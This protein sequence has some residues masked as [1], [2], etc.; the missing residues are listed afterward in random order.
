MRGVGVTSE[1]K[2]GASHEP[3]FTHLVFSWSVDDIRN[4]D[5]YRNQVEK[6]PES[7]QSVGVYLGSFVY[8]LLEETR[9][10]LAS[11]MDIIYGAPFAEVNSLVER[12]LN[13]TDA[14]LRYDVVVDYWRNKFSDR[15]KEPYRTLPG[16]V[17][18][19]SNAKLETVSDL[20]RDGRTWT[21][22]LVT[23]I[24]EDGIEDDSSSSTIFTVKASK[25]IEIK[26]GMRES[27]F[28]TFLMNITTYQRIWNSLRMPKNL[29]IIKEVLC[30]DS[31][32]Q[33]DCELCCVSQFPKSF[34]TSLLSKLN[35]FQIQ[36][37]VASLHRIKCDHKP[38][39]ELIWGPPGTG[40][41]KTVSV[42]LFALL[43][44]NYR[45]LA[46]A[47]TNV[48]IREV[49]SRVLML[50]RES[51][52][53]EEKGALFCCWGDILLFGNKDRLKL[54]SDI[55]E[56]YLDY[57]VKR[58]AECLGP[59]TGWRHCLTS[60]R[61]F[62]EGCVSE[63]DV[64]VENEMI[65]QK[66]M[67]EQKEC[68]N[69]DESGKV[70]IKSFV[71]FVRGRFKSTALSLRRC[72]FV[73]CTHFPRRFILEQNFTSMRSL[74]GLLYD[75]EMSL[76]RD[77]ITTEEL[78][79]VFSR[80]DG[81]EEF[82]ESIVG[83]PSL[84][85]TRSK[86]LCVVKTL[87]HSLEEL[88]LPS[89][90]NKDSMMEFCFQRA[91]LIF[92]TAST[93]YKLRSV[94]ME[95]LDLL[96]IDEAAQLK[97]CESTIP[98]Q[99]PGLNHA[100]LAGDQCQLPAMVHSKVC[101][102]A[103]FG[104]SLF[105]RLS[106]SGHSKHLLN[107]QYRMHPSISLFPNAKFYLNQIMDAPH[108]QSKSYEKQYLPGPMFGP[109]SFINVIGGREEVDDDGR[110]RRNMVEV[111]IVVKIVQHL[112]TAW[113][114]SGNTLSIGV[115]S[116]YA[117]QVVA[118]QDKLG[119]KY[120][121][122]DGFTVKVKTIDGFQ[123]GEE[124]VVV[125]S[126]VRSNNTGSVGFLSSPQR[127]NVALTRARHCLWIL[128]NDRTLSN[129]DSIWEALVHD[130]KSR[131]CFFYAD[132]D[133]DIAKT[134]LD[135]KKEL[136]QLDDLLNENSVLF[137][138]ARWK[139]LFSDNFK[140]SFKKLS[141]LRI[142]KSII[143]LLLKLS[144]GWRPKMR[145]MGQPCKGSSQILKRFKVE[146]L[147]VVC[148]IDIKKESTYFQVLKVWDIL[149][150]EEIPKLIKRLEGMFALY[151][152]DFISHCKEK[153][154]EGDL[155][156]PRRWVQSV[157]I[158]QFK[159]RGNRELGDEASEGIIDER[160]Y[161]ENTKVS[162]SL[163][164]MKFYS[165]SSGVVSHLLSDRDGRELDLPFEVTDQELEIIL[166]QKSTFI[167]G[168]SGT[169]KTTVLTMKLFQKEQ[170]YHIASGGLH[171]GETSTGTDVSQR[172]GFDKCI[173]EVNGSILRQLF[174]TVSPKLCFAVKKHVS[175][176][177]RFSGGGN[178][179]EENSSIDMDDAAQFNDIPDS[180]LNIDPSK[181]PLVVTF[182][183][184]LMMLDGT[185]G[186]SYFERFL[187]PRELFHC[188][189]S[190]SRSVAL[191]TFIRTKEVNYE[192]F[193]TEYWP[194]FN[195]LRTKK[196]DPS[197][198]F[199]EIIS[200]IKGGLGAGKTQEGK[201][202][203]K[204]YVSLSEGRTTLNKAKRE[205]IYAVFQDYE[206]RKMENGEF[207]LSDFVNDLHL[208]LKRDKFEGEAMDFVYIDEVQDLTMRQ[209]ALF[210][211]VCRN[212]EEGFVF[213]GD[214]AQTIARGIDFR[215]QDIRSL[216][217]NEFVMD[218]KG[219]SCDGRK[220]KGHISEIKSLSQNFRTHDGVLRLAQSV[221]DLLYH[222]FHHSIDVLEPEMSL[223]Y[224]E[225][226]LLLESGNDE[227]AIVTIFGKS[228]N[229]G[230]DIVGF[231]AEQVILVRDDCARKETSS[232][233]GKQALVLTIVECK[234]LEFQD[235]LLYNF[236]GSSPLKNQWRV[237]YQFMK[238][239]DLL[240]ASVPSQSFNEAKHNVLCSELK[241]LYVA[242]TRTRQ[243][244][245]I[246]E[247]NEELS[248]PIFDYWK[249]KS[250]VQVKQLD[251]SLAQAMQVASS[252]EEW[253][254]RGIKLFY[255][256]NF[257]MAT[258]CFER[259]GDTMWERRAKASGLKAAADR[260][261]GSNP[262][263]AR[264]DLRQAAE[265]FDS[266]GR[267]ESAA[268]CFC[269]LGEY[270]TAGRLYLD[271]CGESRLEK[272][273][274]CFSLAGCHKLAAEVYAR[275]NYFSEC[276]SVCTQGKLFDMGL[277]YIHYWKQHAARDNVM[278]KRG[279][280]ID[281]IEQQFL[282]SCALHYYELKDNQYMMKFVMAFNSMDAKRNFLKS[283][284]C[285][286]ELLVVEEES[287][288]F[289]E[290]AEIAKL[291][292]DLL[293]EADLL[294]KAEHFNEASML[295]LWYAFS[296]SLW[297]SRGRGWPLRDFARK[298]EIV[299]KA[300]SFAGKTESNVFYEFVCT[301]AN[302]LSK[303]EMGLLQLNQYL[304]ASR[305]N[306]SLRGEFLSIR[307]ILDLHSKISKYE[308]EDE[309]ADD[310]LIKH[311]GE[312]ISHNRVSVG[313]LM[314]FWNLWKDKVEHIFEYL[315]CL[316][317][318]D[319]S[320]HINYD[321]FVLNYFGVRRQLK[322]TNTSYLFLIPDADW[323]REIDDRYLR[324]SGK[325]VSADAR[326]FVSAAK[327]H[328][329]SE[330]LAVG[331]KVLETLE[332]LH[333]LAIKNASCV[334][335]QSLLLLHIFEVTKFLLGSKY[336]DRKYHDT[337]SLDMFL[338]LSMGYFHN[339]FPLE[340]QKSLT[341]NMV[342]LRGTELSRNLLEEVIKKNIPPKGMLTYGQ[343]GRIVMIWLGSGKPSDE[344][345]QKIADRVEGNLP[346]ITYIMDLSGFTA[347]EISK[348]PAKDPFL[349]NPREVASML[350]FYKAL[351]DTYRANWRQ[352]DYVSPSCFLYLVDRLLVLTFRSTGLLFITKSSLV[353]WLICEQPNANQTPNAVPD[354][355]IFSGIF[356]FVVGIIKEILYNKQV[357]AE[358]IRKSGI[359]F[360][361]YYPL[362]VLKLVITL[363]LLVVNSGRY[364]NI[365]YEMLRKGDIT[366]WL[367][368][369]FSDVLRRRNR[370]SRMHVNAN[371][372]A[373]A[374]VKIG[375]PLVIVSWRENCS[376]IAI[377]AAS[378][379][380]MRVAHCRAD[381]MSLLFPVKNQPSKGTTAN[382][383]CKQN[384]SEKSSEEGKPSGAP[385][386]DL[387]SMEDQKM[388]NEN[389][390]EGKQQINC[391]L[392][393]EI[394]DALKSLENIN[395]GNPTKFVSIASRMKLKAE[396]ENSISLISDAMT[397]FSKEPSS[398]EDRSIFAQ[399]KDMLDQLKLLLS[400]LDSRE[401]EENIFAV[402]DCLRR[403]QLR[404]PTMEPFLNQ[405]LPINAKASVVV[406]SEIGEK[407]G[408]QS[409]VEETGKTG[410]GKTSE[411]TLPSGT[412]NT[413]GI[414]PAE[415][416][417]GKASKSKK[418]KKFNKGG[419]RK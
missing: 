254:S 317:T 235:V 191:E 197:R 245:W 74:V 307:K 232:Y 113:R 198:V 412:Q 38:T 164:L 68:S 379:V 123:G 320:K 200:H 138:S 293:L 193:C 384:S 159:N 205:T 221:I 261:R 323:V 28:V 248:K 304:D 233:V 170:L 107:I 333:K 57:R 303:E 236:F 229:A 142:K 394:S 252:P 331:M 46:C 396:V 264:T 110:S 169:G 116:P 199:T 101:E 106:L 50:V 2:T 12:K 246:C 302:I 42:M 268:E 312:R 244:L 115:V 98:L 58:L 217:Y 79:E 87:Q 108:V 417:K 11:S 342:S 345:C 341:K 144:S 125:I 369:E 305:H 219:D 321:D 300:M 406:E 269:D 407:E 102:E 134:I 109:Y 213:A 374:L 324:R 231:G 140:M 270:E 83:M 414:P 265:I 281:K 381:I 325:L 93:S 398:D 3:E 131:Q 37:I 256:N 203:Q 295:M 395:G 419:R 141:S 388:V 104:R 364:F 289:L 337:R 181:Y 130:A 174:V 166:F 103:Q 288:N 215:F 84:K 155:E 69:Q 282:E 207:D 96:V 339:V 204:D 336:L 40:K 139:V 190:S 5:L 296:N 172:N 361:V 35:K 415:S 88:D 133:N 31:L 275:G 411:A 387:V 409:K 287:G 152:D 299:A 41:T 148:S 78:K 392:F 241:Q 349:Q 350:N 326:Q 127:T 15:C 66:E 371:V 385:D 157:D 362:M 71:E 262:E 147:Y 226:P 121:K 216:F 73:F 7:F 36:A 366:N 250:L 211:Y 85:N 237:I 354:I 13:L 301:E 179:S 39:V 180:F 177:K 373:E 8:P 351:D 100:I 24:T 277:Q 6:I 189:S 183:K 64:F 347:S 195:C 330:L 99:L 111:A 372:L 114:I 222:F 192:R 405:L 201:L 54:D 247:N 150:L 119:K 413:G 334:S 95:P 358:W 363:C 306:K 112:Y 16:D 390:D 298:E 43:M 416:S 202:S 367:P 271:K 62:L 360:N 257:E 225:A 352:S 292:G 319:V 393:L 77:N 48:A 137:K 276:L 132:Q 22:A 309:L 19:I 143:N 399:S 26:D 165:L 94:E 400:A 279:K 27:L 176:L 20:Q 238:E 61:D 206:K 243:R 25:D 158:V 234:G 223:I 167:L 335:G 239:L 318:D 212:V 255:E 294:G 365:L 273:G 280:E 375:D 290:A 182:H 401:P 251:D 59:L 316:E 327:S 10:E 263:W 120:E 370:N 187:G 332:L 52:E 403:L 397:N 408:D 253:K 160:S 97:E 266:I 353:E 196:L 286:D 63:Y 310:H 129:S 47:P 4:E 285:L 45:V 122:L 124:D 44:M 128:G 311:S 230:G 91:S 402:K 1:E 117:A 149:P 171:A 161:V 105:E 227:N 380:D 328:W 357:T 359:N 92:C 356:E 267:A 284:N 272:A 153:C 56:I 343:I 338:E 55:E 378:F 156:V 297:A 118:I 240:D 355:R 274:E 344:L 377:P 163:L 65:K 210:K 391:G 70:E 209:I 242:I 146:G 49:A 382:S 228:G 126:T 18:I 315:G 173:A 410:K 145:H 60:M 162:E 308:W 386:S 194:H 72:I 188:K 258:M 220:E 185:V 80:K 340:W 329:S 33:E 34:A 76:F 154:L 214:T 249:K 53:A 75:L 168:R 278:V 383:S 348:E 23:K 376:N 29:K 208:R 67:I 322:N 186:N 346:W 404:R 21:F 151:T 136:D 14:T 81:G 30:T 218:S 82:C 259:A 314:Y 32:A 17:C 178:L 9:A 135:V 389:T 291:K 224:G 90:L 313:T 418:G 184:F 51:F 175:G 368:R 283:L 89:V 260:M 86:C